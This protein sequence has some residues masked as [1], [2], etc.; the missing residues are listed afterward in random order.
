LPDNSPLRLLIQPIHSEAQ[1]RRAY[2]PLAEY[3]AHALK[4]EVTILAPPNPVAYWDLVR[5]G[6][7]FDLAFD[8]AHFTDYRIQR[9]GF[10][11]LVKAPETMSYSLVASESR[12]V[13]NPMELVG[14]SIAT[15]GLPSIGAVR[16]TAMFLNPARQPHI[17]EVAS[18][19]EALELLTKNRAQAAILPTDYAREQMERGV[20]LRVVTTTEPLPNIALSAAPGIDAGTRERLRV[21]LLNAQRS[22][23]GR[24]ML[25]AAGLSRFEPADAGLYSGHARVLQKYWGYEAEKR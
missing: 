6:Q 20:R 8:E 25:A 11:V 19:E 3:L 15:L 21:L 16:L 2:Q 23:D 5:R 1:T 10:E 24:R 7:G 13:R 9:H 4:R 12:E 18:A 17:L 14:K 22:P